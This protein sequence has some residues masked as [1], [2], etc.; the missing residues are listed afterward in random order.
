MCLAMHPERGKAKQ[1]LRAAVLRDAPST[2][3]APMLVSRGGRL[4]AISAAA[5]G[6]AAAVRAAVRESQSSA[7]QERTHRAVFSARRASTAASGRRRRRA[8]Q[9]VRSAGRKLLLRDRTARAARCSG[10]AGDSARGAARPARRRALGCVRPGEATG[11]LRPETLLGRVSQKAATRHS[12]TSLRAAR[13]QRTTGTTS[14]DVAS[15]VAP[16]DRPPRRQYAPAPPSPAEPRN[17]AC[18][19]EWPRPPN[20]APAAR[21]R[22]SQQR[23]PRA[24]GGHA[25]AC[26]PM[27]SHPCSCAP[28]QRSASA[29]RS[30]VLAQ[31]HLLAQHA[32]A[33]VQPRVHQA[34]HG[35]DAAHDGAHRRHKVQ[36]RRTR[37]RKP[38]L[39]QERRDAVSRRTGRRADAKHT[40]ERL[41]A[42]ACLD[43]VDVVKEEDPRQR[44][45]RHDVHRP[46]VRRRR[47]SRAA[48]KA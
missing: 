14:R 3:R 1:L 26:P 37:L 46:V 15:Q 31:L 16:S 23:S 9:R 11:S 2:Q 39:R 13:R 18:S 33:V 10:A 41:R 25:R 38:H 48:W 35:E 20:P 40:G 4:Y 12:T 45:P 17:A 30:H 28:L 22:G 44:A 29:R 19:C 5:T 7:R 32:R 42:W 36:E 24:R 21:H 43:R 6:E 27:L 34:R 8:G 47:V